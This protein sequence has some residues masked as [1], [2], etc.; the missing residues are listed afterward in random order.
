[1]KELSLEEL[2]KVTG[3]RTLSVDDIRYQSVSEAHAKFIYEIATITCFD[4]ILG[5][6]M[7]EFKETEEIRYFDAPSSAMCWC[8]QRFW[9][10]HPYDTI[11]F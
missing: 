11:P 2:K 1:M 8:C 4:G 5:E 3:G 7:V 6:C 9:E 10:L